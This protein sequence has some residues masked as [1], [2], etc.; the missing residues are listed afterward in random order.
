ML[1]VTLLQLWC[2]T[3]TNLTKGYGSEK[4]EQMKHQL[5]I[6]FVI[7][8]FRLSQ[9]PPW[10]AS[11]RM[12]EDLLVFSTS[13]PGGLTI[14]TPR[15]MVNYFIL[16]SFILHVVGLACLWALWYYL[17]FTTVFPFHHRVFYCRD[18]DLYKPNYV[19]EDFNVYVSDTLLYSL[20]FTLPPLVVD[21]HRRSDVLAFF[22]EAAENGVCELRRMQSAPLHEETTEIHRFPVVFRF[23][24]VVMHGYVFCSGNDL[25]TSD[26][27]VII[28][29]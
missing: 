29:M 12:A 15:P 11:Q 4:S 9:A 17:R 7:A 27:L 21:I 28:F 1:G 13:Q 8:P 26:S 20:G 16:P 3:L 14:S 23:G 2:V 22:N 25:P 24:P 10:V 18:V 6:A 5:Q 19:P